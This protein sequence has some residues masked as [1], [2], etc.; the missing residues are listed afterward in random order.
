MVLI[1]HFFHRDLLTGRPPPSHPVLRFTR[2]RRL[3]RVL[4]MVAVAL[5]IAS[6]SM[7]D[8]THTAANDNTIKSLHE[9]STIIF[10][11]LT[12]LQALQTLRLV[13]DEQLGGGL[14]RSLVSC[15]AHL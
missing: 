12:A 15:P 4:L 5:G 7:T 11:V 2:N 3:F 6:S 1:S 8:A 10:L 9:A 14:S 13:K